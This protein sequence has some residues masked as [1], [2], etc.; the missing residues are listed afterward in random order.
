MQLQWLE[1][2]LASAESW[3]KFIITNHIYF[4]AQLKDNVF[5][6]LWTEDYT[7]RFAAILERYADKII[8]EL[9]GHEHLG[10]VRQ[11]E[12][13]IFYKGSPLMMGVSSAE[14]KMLNLTFVGPQRY[15]NMLIDPG[16]TAFDGQNPGFSTLQF[17]L[18]R[19]VFYDLK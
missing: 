9:S 11:H 10:D 5:K 8:I 4:G 16:M 15:H 14:E 6:R 18:K 13:S 19:Q 1:E 17:D 3:R 12:G 2:Q 7:L